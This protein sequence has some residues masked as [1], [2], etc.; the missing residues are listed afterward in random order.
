[1]FILYS[2]FQNISSYIVIYGTIDTY[3]VFF[4]IYVDNN[5]RL[6]RCTQYLMVWSSFLNQ[7]ILFYKYDCRGGTDHCILDNLIL[8]SET[9]HY[10]DTT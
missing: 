2:C 5:I 1:M 8:F 7:I 3:R 4:I 10:E 6:I 9:L